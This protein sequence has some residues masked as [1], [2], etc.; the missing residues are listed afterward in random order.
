[1]GGFGYTLKLDVI[2]RSIDPVEDF[3]VNRK[4]GATASILRS[5][6]RQRSCSAPWA[7]PPAW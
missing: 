1:M 4:A 5:F 2:D 3:L 6:S 7:F